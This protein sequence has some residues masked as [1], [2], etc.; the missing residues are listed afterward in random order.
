MVSLRCLLVAASA[1]AADGAL[2]QDADLDIDT[3]ADGDECAAEVGEAPECAVSALQTAARSL[4]VKSQHA[5]G[6]R[7]GSGGEASCH[8]AVAGEACYGEVEW[9]MSSGIFEHPEWYPGLSQHSSHADFQ[10]QVHSSRPHVC[11]APCVSGAT[12]W[13]RSAAGVHLWA[14]AQ[15]SSATSIKILSYNTYWWNLFKTRHGDHDSAGKLIRANAQP[16]FDVMGFQECEDISQV[17]GPVGL[18]SQYAAFSGH[19]ALCMAYNREAW[20]LVARGAEDVAE[21]MSKPSYGRRSVQWMRLRNV[22]TGL[23]LFFVNHHGPLSINSGG[24]CGGEATANHLLQTIAQHA[25]HGDTVVLVGD[26]NANA[27]GLTI[28]TLWSY[29]VHI[30]AGQS[31]GGVDNI[32][33]NAAAED[34]LETKIMGKGGSDHDAITAT[35]QVGGVPPRQ[36]SYSGGAAVEAVKTL[37]GAAKPGFFTNYW[38]GLIEADTGYLFAGSSHLGAISASVKQADAIGAIDHDWCC[39]ECQ[40]DAN[41]TAWLWRAH[42]DSGGGHECLLSSEAPSSKRSV[43]GCV[44]GLP[45]TAAA[46]QAH[47]SAA[48]A[49]KHL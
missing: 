18:S 16:P 14:P 22:H 15:G 26:F 11:P 48:S 34:I 32:F 35:I 8:T 30:F 41:C 24:L 46:Q 37:T 21:D 17:L 9:A 10:Q 20:S 42:S 7:Q 33:S 4:H 3:F 38:C 25:H 39:R 36:G 12:R 13:C 49:V 5:Q 23:L 43:R 29:L 45:Y 19:R 44:S 40:V 47:R 2:L 31:F 1:V 27:G 6:Q 28:Q